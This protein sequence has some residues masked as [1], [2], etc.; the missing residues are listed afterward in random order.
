MAMEQIARHISY[1]PIGVFFTD[2]KTG[3]LVSVNRP[4]M[5]TITM[6]HRA[7]GTTGCFFY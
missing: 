3:Q 7:T 1:I 5:M 2:T 6:T 4:M